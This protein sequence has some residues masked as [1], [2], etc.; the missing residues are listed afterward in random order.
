MKTMLILLTTALT[1]GVSAFILFTH[2]VS[3]QPASI[4]VSILSD[5]TDDFIAQPDATEVVLML[6]L[7]QHMWG[8]AKLNIQTITDVDYNTV[9]SLY[10]PDRF[11][12]LS[13]PTARDKEIADFKQAVEKSIDTVNSEKIG[14]TGSNICAPLFRELNRIALSGA[15]IK[16]VILYSDMEENSQFFSVYR[17]A[18][19]AMLKNNPEAA[20]KF[21]KRFGELGNLHG[22]EVYFVFQPQ[23]RLDNEYFR[24]MTNFL[25]PLL[26]QAG[27]AV[28]IGANLV[29]Q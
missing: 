7:E 27:A 12:L 21:F 19:L 17:D 3:W 29:T 28:Y 22:V 6:N 18:D 20:A 26:E 4:E 24:V 8:K 16:R 1:L 23:T 15:D 10:L 14:Y 2:H 11:I 5:K 13:N 9:H 25:K